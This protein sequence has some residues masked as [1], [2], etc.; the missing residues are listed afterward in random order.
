MANLGSTAEV[1]R[2]TGINSDQ[3][4][5]SEIIAYLDQA[6][7]RIK[8]RHYRKYMQDMFYANSVGASGAVNRS[9]ETYFPVKSSTDIEV[10]INGV[11]Q[12]ENTHYI[13]T[14]SIITFDSNTNLHHGD[15]IHFFYQPDFYDDYASYLAAKRIFSMAVIDSNNEIVQANLQNYTEAIAEF[16]K[17]IAKKP[18][19]A[20]FVDHAEDY[21]IF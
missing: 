2:I 21:G 17:M 4:S 15:V 10:Y 12:V 1:R 18:H 11:L 6:E 20:R 16:E 7:R 14:D 3:L 9:Y 8:A 5:D 19:C 13:Q